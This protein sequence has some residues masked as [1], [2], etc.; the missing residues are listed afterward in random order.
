MMV[1]RDPLTSSGSFIT[2]HLL[3]LG[4]S[5]LIMPPQLDV[6][7]GTILLRMR[8]SHGL[9][10]QHFS[11]VTASLPCVC[12]ASAEGPTPADGM[13][14]QRSRGRTFFVKAE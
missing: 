7:T 11:I 5:L 6:C 2:R 4:I 3:F 13:A 14:V 10:F 12:A 1:F 8:I 9:R